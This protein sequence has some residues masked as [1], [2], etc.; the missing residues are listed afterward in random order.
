MGIRTVVTLAV[1]FLPSCAMDV[2]AVGAH[3]Q[4]ILGELVDPKD[5]SVV[6]IRLTDGSTCTGAVI[7]R[8]QILTALHCVEDVAPDD[9]EVWE[10]PD[11]LGGD[12]VLLVDAG[13]VASIGTPE[14]PLVDLAVLETE[15]DLGLEPIVVAPASPR[16][17]DRLRVVGYGEQDG[18]AFDGRK[19]DASTTVKQRV[20]SRLY[21]TPVT[22]FG[23]SGAPVLD[24]EGR[25]TGVVSAGTDI[26]CG[27][28]LDVY[29]SLE[30]APELFEPSPRGT[31]GCSAVP[32]AAVRT[33]VP[34]GLIVLIAGPRLLRRRRVSRRR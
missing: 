12:G 31:S 33:E 29:Q 13:G 4:T 23:D 18:G 27:M 15:G 14:A 9:I 20:R 24:P 6:L 32:A 10:G 2:R 19:R 26:R 22:C 5:P 30:A 28:G 17:G 7:E 3:E 21:A 1:V 25:L 34:A 8:R 11:P 16:V